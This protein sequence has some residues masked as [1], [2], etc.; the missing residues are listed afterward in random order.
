MLSPLVVFGLAC[1]KVNRYY[2][3]KQVQRQQK[4]FYLVA[5]AAGSVS[6]LA[7]VGYW[8][9]RV[10]QMNHATVPFIALLTLERLIYASRVLSIAALGCLLVGRG[11]YRIPLALAILWVTVHLW[12]HGSIIHW[13]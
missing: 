13:A 10:F 4:V 5:L 12:A 2:N 3:R 6:T 9:W 8:G 7:Y 11:P 1:A